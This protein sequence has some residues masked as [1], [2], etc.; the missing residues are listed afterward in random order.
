M[1]ILRDRRIRLLSSLTSSIVIVVTPERGFRCLAI[2]ETGGF[3]ASRMIGND[4]PPPGAARPGQR[5][6]CAVL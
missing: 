5:R 2:M 3:G 1:R 4:W 6:V